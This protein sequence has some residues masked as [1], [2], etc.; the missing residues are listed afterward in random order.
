MRPDGVLQQWVQFHHIEKLDLIR[1]IGSL[2]EVFP[3]V[4]L[5]ES[6]GQGMLTAS[7]TER[8][9]DFE[10]IAKYDAMVEGADMMANF[11]ELLLQPAEVDAALADYRSTSDHPADYLLS[12]DEHPYLEYS[13][14]RGYVLV[15]SEIENVKYFG[16]FRDWE[17]PTFKVPPT[18]A[19]RSAYEAALKR[20]DEERTREKKLRLAEK[21]GKKKK[22]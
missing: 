2:R 10:R 12:T 9:F 20:R 6:G 5:W 15:N 11:R 7:L 4:H 8:P 14:P 22:P 18:A 16:R 21:H 3:Y 19:Q 17:I 13:T 1:I